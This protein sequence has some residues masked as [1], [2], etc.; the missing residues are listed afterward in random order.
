ML[1][2]E[3]G[4]GVIPKTR[5]D[6][7]SG[8]AFAT[9]FPVTCCTRDAARKVMTTTEKGVTPERVGIILMREDREL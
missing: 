5:C 6:T 9:N 2:P 8:H 7:A 3:G 1:S 4:S